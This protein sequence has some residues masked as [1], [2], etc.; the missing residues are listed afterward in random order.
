MNIISGLKLQ[1]ILKKY[2]R[3]RSEVPVLL[4]RFQIGIRRISF[5]P[6]WLCSPALYINDK[7]ITK[8]NFVFGK[9]SLS[10]ERLNIE[11]NS[12]RQGNSIL[13]VAITV[14]DMDGI[15]GVYIP[16][17]I[18][19]DVAKESSDRA[20]Q[21]VALNSP[22]PSIGAQAGSA[23]IEA[24]KNLSTKKVKLITVIVKAGYRVLLKDKK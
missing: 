17:A 8:G 3:L 23:G 4:I 20:I 5:L 14:Y 21:G 24:A 11:I 2:S 10:G 19:R 13:S 9:A 18:S 6:C 22:D 16:E 15:D 7:H 12:V 1:N